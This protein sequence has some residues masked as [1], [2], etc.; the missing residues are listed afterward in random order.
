VR[1]ANDHDRSP[2]VD[3]RQN[4]PDF[5][6]KSAAIVEADCKEVSEAAGNFLN[7]ICGWT[8]SLLAQ[9]YSGM[10]IAKIRT[11]YRRGDLNPD[12]IEHFKSWRK[13]AAPGW[14]NRRR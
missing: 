5:S 9:F 14:L 3:R 12:P 4:T 8:K 1:A 13:L 2:N 10:N 7:H 6:R 11:D